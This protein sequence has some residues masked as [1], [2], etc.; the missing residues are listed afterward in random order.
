MD[1]FEDIFEETEEEK[2][3]KQIRNMF[4]LAQKNK[5]KIPRYKGAPPGSS[6][7][8]KYWATLAYVDET[9]K[10]EGEETVWDVYF[11]ATEKHP[12]FVNF[13][14]TANAA[15]EV[16]VK[17]SYWGTWNAKSKNFLPRRDLGLLS[18]FRPG[19]YNKLVEVLTE[20]SK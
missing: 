19:L 6:K 14:L 12:H 16:A 17:G 9:E 13:K 5:N 2:C 8:F 1:M 10:V 15:S 20:L 7:Y 4:S 3:A 11:Y 18:D